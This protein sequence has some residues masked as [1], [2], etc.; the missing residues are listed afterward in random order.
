MAKPASENFR[1]VPTAQDESEA[2]S[3]DA[4]GVRLAADEEVRWVWRHSLLAG[5]R[6]IGYAITKKESAEH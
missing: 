2:N 6:I 4:S 3:G 5:S 1:W